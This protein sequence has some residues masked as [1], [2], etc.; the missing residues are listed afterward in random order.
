MDEDGEWATVAIGAAVGAVWEGV[1]T[2][3][4]A[5]VNGE[6]VDGKELLINVAKGAVKG[7]VAGSGAH[8]LVGAAVDGIV[9]GVGDIAKQ[10]IVEGKSANEI[11]WGKS[12]RVGASSAAESAVL[13]S[14]MDSKF[15]KGKLSRG[16]KDVLMSEQ[17]EKALKKANGL[18]ER[19]KKAK[20]ILKKSVGKEWDER[21]EGMFKRKKGKFKEALKECT[22]YDFIKE[23][24]DTYT[25]WTKSM[26]E[27]GIVCALGRGGMA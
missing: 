8:W 2:V 22:Y 14:V 5:K 20:D 4:E 27:S 12:V 26:V 1:S 6:K 13:G 21:A 7:A 19:T 24:L 25:D 11:N 10:K 17:Y 16:G 9:D 23:E 3:V 15:V 18:E